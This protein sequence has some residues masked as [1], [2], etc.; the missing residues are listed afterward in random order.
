MA[1]TVKCFNFV[2][3]E[4]WFDLPGNLDQ[5]GSQLLLGKRQLLPHRDYL[6]ANDK[7]V[8]FIEKNANLGVIENKCLL[9]QPVNI[10][11]LYATLIFPFLVCIIEFAG[12][13]GVGEEVSVNAELNGEI[14][15]LWQR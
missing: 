10:L 12:E 14:S 4:L 6:G 7:G 5:P 8:G 1:R 3:L 11:K 9:A 2:S 13:F 15:E